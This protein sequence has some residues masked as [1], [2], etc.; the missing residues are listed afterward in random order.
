MVDDTDSLLRG[1]I[2]CLFHLF[3]ELGLEL[4]RRL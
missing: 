3:H 2:L 1:P 4:R